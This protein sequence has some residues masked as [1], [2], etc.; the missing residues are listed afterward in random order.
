M[1]SESAGSQLLESGAGQVEAVGGQPGDVEMVDLEKG[2]GAG[3]VGKQPEI[4][5]PEK[6]GESI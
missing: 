5:T 3:Q 1:R 6:V 2:E 4:S